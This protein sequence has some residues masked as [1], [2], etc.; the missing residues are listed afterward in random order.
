MVS[1]KLF[2]AAMVA[3]FA[4]PHLASQPPKQ[5]PASVVAQVANFAAPIYSSD[6]CTAH[7]C[8]KTQGDQCRYNYNVKAQ[9]YVQ[10]C[11]GAQHCVAYRSEPHYCHG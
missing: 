9:R 10:H 4:I 1:A 7:V 6:G 2:A 5:K 11:W 8:V 3:F